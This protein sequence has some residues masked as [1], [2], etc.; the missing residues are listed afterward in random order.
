MGTIYTLEIKILTLGGS[1]SLIL[2][3]MGHKTESIVYIHRVLFASFATYVRVDIGVGKNK[4]CR[5]K[6]QYNPM[7]LF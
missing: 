7:L 5:V 4:K 3:E 6:R 2:H 1:V